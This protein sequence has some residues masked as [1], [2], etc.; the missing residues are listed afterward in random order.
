MILSKLVIKTLLLSF[1]FKHL[2]IRRLFSKNNNEFNGVMVL[3]FT[4]LRIDE[5]VWLTID[6]TTMAIWRVNEKMF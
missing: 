4:N 3:T 6:S 5:L 1:H 2:S